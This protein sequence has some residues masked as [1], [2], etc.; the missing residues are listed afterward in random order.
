MYGI[1]SKSVLLRKTE[2]KWAQNGV[3]YWFY[4]LIVDYNIHKAQG[5]I[6]A[7]TYNYRNKDYFIFTSK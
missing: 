1:L 6:K 3:L 4:T 2:I 7:I 5:T